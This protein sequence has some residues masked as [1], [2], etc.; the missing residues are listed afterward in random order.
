MRA[1]TQGEPPPK[2]LG[3][4]PPPKKLS[5]QPALGYFWASAT[6]TSTAEGG[7]VAV[8]CCRTPS[9]STGSSQ[10]AVVSFPACHK[11]RSRGLRAR[12]GSLIS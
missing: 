4:S 7:S 3:Y 12:S 6:Y 10:E 11:S 2:L 1:L 9:W 5:S 8:T